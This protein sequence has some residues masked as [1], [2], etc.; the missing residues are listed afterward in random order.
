[1]GILLKIIRENVQNLERSVAF[2]IGKT[3][4]IYVSYIYTLCNVIMDHKNQPKDNPTK[5][6]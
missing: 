2:I 1:M 5:N 6:H 3:V 4:N